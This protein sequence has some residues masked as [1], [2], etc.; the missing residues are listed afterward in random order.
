MLR[1]AADQHHGVGQWAAGP[2]AAGARDVPEVPAGPGGQP[3]ERAPER[4]LPGRVTGPPT[5]PWPT[6]NTVSSVAASRVSARHAASSGSTMPSL[7]SGPDSLP[8]QHTPALRSQLPAVSLHVSV[9]FPGI[10]RNLDVDR[11]QTVI[12]SPG[13]AASVHAHLSRMSG[14]IPSSMSQPRHIVTG[15]L[16]RPARCAPFPGPGTGRRAGWPVVR[17]ARRE[18]A[19][20]RPAAR[21]H[22]QIGY[23]G[24]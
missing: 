13:V 20:A 18:C 10:I 15:N 6:V 22:F 24:P 3:G 5:V 7:V 4:V 16:V 17:H 8:G 12:V 1:H 2:P 11:W 21:R 9:E 19:G 23:L 14:L